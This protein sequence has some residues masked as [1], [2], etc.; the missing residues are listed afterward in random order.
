MEPDP[1]PFEQRRHRSLRILRLEEL[2]PQLGDL[3]VRRLEIGIG[4]GSRLGNGQDLALQPL[5]EL[6]ILLAPLLSG[7]EL[8]LM[9]RSLGVEGRLELGRDPGTLCLEGLRVLAPA[10]L[11]DPDEFDDLP[12]ERR[13]HGIGGIKSVVGLSDQLLEPFSILVV[14][15]PGLVQRPAKLVDLRALRLAFRAKLLLAAQL[16]AKARDAALGLSARRNQPLQLAVLR[17]ELDIPLTELIG[18]LLVPGPGGFQLP[19]ELRDLASQLLA[20]GMAGLELVPELL[21]PR[22]ELIP[23]GEGGVELI[24]DLLD[25]RPKLVPLGERRTTL[26]L[27]LLDFALIP[28]SAD[29]AELFPDLLDLPDELVSFGADGAELIVDL[30]DPRDEL[31]PF[32]DGGTMVVPDLLDLRAKLVSFGA[33]GVELVLDLLELRAR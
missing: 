28:A 10:L 24:L 9:A 23:L 21:D 8:L 2:P 31:F 5:D 33:G 22:D 16:V 27:D 18:D 30:L 4:H 3:L 14:G 19:V 26:V 32:G 6:G 13:S 7:P 25:L 15:L 12:L 1:H 29:G 17:G 11:L 20:C